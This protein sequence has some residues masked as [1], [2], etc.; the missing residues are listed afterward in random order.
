MHYPR[1]ECPPLQAVETYNL[2]LTGSPD[3]KHLSSLLP[4]AFIL[5]LLIY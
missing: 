1:L 5:R 4:F 3:S 2:L